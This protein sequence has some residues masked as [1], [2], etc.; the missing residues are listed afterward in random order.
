MIVI[1]PSKS[2]Q[3]SANSIVTAGAKPIF[4]DINC[5]SQNIE[6]SDLKKDF[7]KTKSNICVHLGGRR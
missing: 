1:V 7:K 3:S 4:C 2:Y 6:I 5:N